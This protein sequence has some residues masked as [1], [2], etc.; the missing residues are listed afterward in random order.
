[1]SLR[2]AILEHEPESPAAL[3]A[4]WAAARGHA[5]DVLDVPSLDAWPEVG[6]HDVVV[7]LGSDCSVHASPD[8]WIAAEVAFLRRAHDAGV[9]LLG[10]C[11]GGQA[12]ARALGGDV[13][14]APR[15]A[16][17]W[18]E[19]SSADPRLIT[20]GPWLRWHADVFDVPPGGAEL[21][22]GEAGALSFAHGASIGLQFHPEA[23]AALAEAWIDG[24]RDRMVDDG[25]DEARLRREIAAA[26]PGARPRAFDL[27]DRIARR[28]E[29]AGG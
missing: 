5:L 21:M 17:G 28:W 10:I 18:S 15:V 24:A 6:A 23:D 8:A 20:P 3:L 19:L 12:L 22:A 29:F 26:A 1:V 4:E 9:P 13:R 27:F 7:S 11:F 14:R 2:L 25:V 16:A